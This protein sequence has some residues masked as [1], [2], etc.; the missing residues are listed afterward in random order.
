MI[1]TQS[2]VKVRY[3]ETDKMGLV[4]HQNYITYFE[5]SRVDM[6]DV[7]G[8]PYRVLEEKGFFLP[9][10]EV[11]VRYIQ[12]N[13]FDDQL[14]IHCIMEEMP[15]VK[16]KLRYEVYRGDILTNTG[17]SLHGFID[18]TGKPTRPPKCLVEAAGKHF[19]SST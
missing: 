11:M 4:H 7:L 10:I 12:S 16:I 3:A 13:T 2:T 1:H 8:V 18:S 19:Q 9:V 15:K 14:T 6:L 5:L 17:Y